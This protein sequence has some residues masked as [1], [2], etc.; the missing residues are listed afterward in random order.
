MVSFLGFGG[1]L[2]QGS[3]TD[4][5]L[6]LAASFAQ[7]V[8]AAARTLTVAGLGADL[9]DPN[10]MEATADCR[11]KTL[12]EEVAAADCILMAT[13]IYGGTVSGAVKNMLD[14]LHM[15]KQIDQGPL[16]GKKVTV[17]AVGGGALSGR[18]SFQR[19]ATVTMEI[20]CKNLGAWVDPNHL[21]FSELMFDRRHGLTDALARDQLR[22]AVMKL[23]SLTR[24]SR[25]LVPDRG[26]NN[27]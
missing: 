9:F 25:A 10:A 13:P 26:R 12:L 15:G 21:E 23:V 19:G 17:A 4:A 5:L 2:R 8:G 24:A 1:S 16:T 11:I 6:D 18:Y 27:D 20:A 22:E 7:D 3:F 14:I